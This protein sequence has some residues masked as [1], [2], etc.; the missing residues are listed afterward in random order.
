MW[1]LCIV[2]LIFANL[3]ALFETSFQAQTIIVFGQSLLKSGNV[4]T[5]YGRGYL[6]YFKIIKFLSQINICWSG[7]LILKNHKGSI[8]KL[9]KDYWDWFDDFIG[10][11][12]YVPLIPSRQ[13][14]ILLSLARFAFPNAH[15]ALWVILL[16]VARLCF[17]KVDLA[18]V[19]N[20]T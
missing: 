5:F 14:V 9:E 7:S 19:S 12:N 17:P 16:T 11:L 2:F 1:E 15:L 18:T 3:S 4:F 8:E 20:I 10:R 6:V 13:W